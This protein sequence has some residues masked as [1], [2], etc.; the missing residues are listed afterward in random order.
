[1]CGSLRPHHVSRETR[2]QAGLPY[3]KR[4]LQEGLTDYSGRCSA[5]AG[6]RSSRTIIHKVIHS[7]FHGPSLPGLSGLTH[8]SPRPFDQSCWHSAL[9]NRHEQA[10]IVKGRRMAPIWR[11]SFCD[12]GHEPQ[13]TG[14]YV[15]GMRVNHAHTVG[16]Q[17]PRGSWRCTCRWTGFRQFSLISSFGICAPPTL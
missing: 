14:E 8:S 12:Q 10:L 11:Q 7:V 13:T 16:W 5:G 17:T 6:S 4:C 15:D 3:L 2:R 9:P 1:M